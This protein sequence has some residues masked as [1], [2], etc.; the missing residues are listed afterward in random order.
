MAS[1]YAEAVR[2]YGREKAREVWEMTNEN[3]ERM[4]EAVLGQDVGHRR[5]GTAILPGDEEERALLIESEQLLR[6]DGFEA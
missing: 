4:L 3:H 6:E 5:R 2:T 1:S